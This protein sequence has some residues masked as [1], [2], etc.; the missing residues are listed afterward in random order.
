V[1]TECTPNTSYHS[2]TDGQTEIVNKWLEGYL[3]NYVSGKQKAW[4]K[5]IYLGEN[6]YNT[7]HHMF[8]GM[9]PFKAL[10]NYDPFTFFEIVFGD[11]RA[12]ITKEWI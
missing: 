2:Q 8:I 3:R 12:R 5:W 1:G 4:V 7:T 6:C 10:Y 9:S 11:S